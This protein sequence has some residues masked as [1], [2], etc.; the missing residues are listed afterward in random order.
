M[1]ENRSFENLL[2]EIL[3]S[4]PEDIDVRQGSIFYDAVAGV[5][6]S[7]AKL[8][9]DLELVF[10]LSRVD[11]AS[12]E[13]LDTRASEYGVHRHKALPAKY[14][15]V[16]T[17]AIPEDGERFFCGETY[18][19]LRRPKEGAC[20]LECET[21]GNIDL[22]TG[23][24]AVPVNDIPGLASSKFGSVIDYGSDPE[25]DES[26]RLRLKDKISGSGENAN[27]QHYKIWCESI[28]GVGRARIIP[29]WQGPNTVKAVLINTEGY[30]VSSETAEKV[31]NYIDPGSTG[32]GEG[33]APIGAH[34]TAV[35][36][37]ILS[38][39]LTLTA[40]VSEDADTA[41]VKSEIESV[42]REYFKEL[43]VS[44]DEIVIR[45]SE[46]GA[47]ISRINQIVDYS[48]LKLNG[49]GANITVDSESVPLLEVTEIEFVR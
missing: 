2:K 9:T 12:G 45:V 33:A 14:T 27:K 31:Q 38:V 35:S 6:M 32:L 16:F 17:G 10:G 49:S 41:I 44:E 3:E 19:V 30:P 7:I 40:E 43:S 5:T 4:A 37:S 46:I 21:T 48:E 39:K 23:K 26:L 18:F 24:N 1:F 36:A 22:M 15:A 42:V 47:R 13:Y 28:E 20:Y 8:Y 29:L 11:T 25:D 34:F